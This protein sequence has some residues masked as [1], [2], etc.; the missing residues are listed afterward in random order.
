MSPVVTNRL[1]AKTVRLAQSP[2]WT[3]QRAAWLLRS[4]AGTD[5]LTAAQALSEIRLGTADG[6]KPDRVMLR[7]VDSLTVLIDELSRVRTRIVLPV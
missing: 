6:A 2:E 1:V 4:T 3:A 5:A 7:A